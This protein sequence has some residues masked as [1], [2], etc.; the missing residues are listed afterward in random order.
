VERI[1]GSSVTTQALKVG[2]VGCGVIAQVMHLTHLAEL[3]TEFALRSVCDLSEA[4]A[5]SCAERYGAASWYTAPADMLAHEDLDL[6]FDL[7]AGSHAPIAIDAA[8]SGRHVFVEK[9]MCLSID[10]GRQI[11]DALRAGRR[12]MMVGT[13]KRF[14]PAYQRLHELL[15]ATDLRLV[16]STT[17]ETPQAA[18]YEH[19]GV[20]VLPGAD[21]AALAAVKA[22]HERRLEEALPD[23]T[24]EE[25]YCYRWMLL[26]NL[27]HEFNM[28]RGLL[29]EPTQ[30]RYASVTRDV[31]N[32]ALRFGDID[33]HL[34]WVD[35][36]GMSHYRQELSFHGANERL[37]LT[38]PSPYLRNM[39]TR[40]TI[41]RGDGDRPY[42]STTVE[43][44]SYQSAFKCELR[45]LAAAIADDRDPLTN[46]IEGLRDIALC[47]AVIRSH[48]RRV[49][50]D[51]PTTLPDWAVDERAGQPVVAR[52]ARSA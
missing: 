41:E 36:P 21:A 19:L 29:G 3:R 50:I 48:Q 39:P 45:E 1:G 18:Y 49:P 27:V 24:D 30:V 15:P 11:H 13:H 17:L 43:T 8:T 52:G 23:A 9:P 37:I 10:E 4:T 32:V 6:V 31:V 28:L 46:V 33:C 26:D 12:R 44:M 34:S 7:T 14:D 2:V 20:Q 47:E 25:R 22:D 40:L 16:Q 38:L 42:S 51:D 5:R 35:L